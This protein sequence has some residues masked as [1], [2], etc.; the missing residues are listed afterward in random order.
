M[1]N[2]FLFFQGTEYALKYLR[3]Q[4]PNLEILSISGNYCADK[5]ASAINWYV[6]LYQLISS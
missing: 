4:F 2:D 5:K 6:K 3:T 1:I